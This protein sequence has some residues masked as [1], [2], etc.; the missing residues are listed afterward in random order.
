[1]AEES[2]LRETA[3][4]LNGC[5]AFNGK[6]PISQPISFWTEQDILRYIQRYNIPYASIYGEIVPEDDQIRFEQT[7]YKLKTTG[8]SRT[9]C[10][11]CAFGAHL[12]KGETRFQ[13]LKKTH[14]KQ[15]DYC[16]SGGEYNDAGI[17]TPN[18][19]GLGMRHVFDELNRIYGESFI[20]YE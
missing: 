2:A 15:Y 19:Q 17:W 6:R 16:L 14:P 18:Q 9:G 1:M 10:I 20:R 3:W 7:E 8:C 11:F 4:L 12:D 5:N 13:R